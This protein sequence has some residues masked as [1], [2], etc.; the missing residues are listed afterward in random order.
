MAGGKVLEV[1]RR[2]GCMTMWTHMM[3]LNYPLENG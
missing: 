1:E 2:D 3:P